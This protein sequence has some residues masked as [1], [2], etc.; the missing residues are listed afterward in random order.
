[1]LKKDV[2]VLLINSGFNRRVQYGFLN[3]VVTPGLPLSL[4][5]LGGYLERKGVRVKIADEQVDDLSGNNLRDLIRDFKPHVVGLSC[6]TPTVYRG[7]ELAERIKSISNDT[8]VVMGNAHPSI[9]PEECLKEENIDLVIRGEGEVTFWECIEWLQGKREIDAILGLSFKKNGQIQHNTDRPFVQ[10]L[11]DFPNFAYHLLMTEPFRYNPGH[12]VTSRGCPYRCIFCSSRNLSGYSYRTFSPQRVAE[13]VELLIKEYRIKS[14]MF[15]DDNFVVNRNRTFEICE[16]FLRNGYAK[17]ITWRCQ[18]RG[19]LVDREI[20]KKM[21]EAGCVNISFGIETASQRLLDLI[22]KNEKVEDNIKAVQLASEVG[23]KTRGAF[24]LGLPTET[25]EESM[26]T[27]RLAKRLPL[28]EVKFSLATP[29]PGTELYNIAKQR[30]YSLEGKWDFLNTTVGLGGYEPVYCPAGRTPAELKALQRRAHLEFYLRPHI[31]VNLFD[32]HQPDNITSLPPIRNP[33]ILFNYLKIIF[34]FLFET[35]KLKYKRKSDKLSVDEL[36]PR[37]YFLSE[38]CDGYQ[39]FKRGKELSYVK[40]KEV[41]FLDPQ[42]G[43]FILD[44]GC[45]RGELLFYCANQGARVVGI[46][47]ASGAIELAKETLDK[48]GYILKARAAY[49]PFKDG[50]FDKVIL[51][52]VLEHLEPTEALACMREMSRVSRLGGTILIHTS[53]NLNFV[54]ISGLVR[55][56]LIL[57]GKTKLAKVLHDKLRQA[58]HRHINIQSPYSFRRLI[59][60]IEQRALVWI[61]KDFL[62][63]GQSPLTSELKKSKFL[64]LI[65]GF[66]I[67]DNFLGN[68][69]WALIKVEKK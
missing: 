37:D 50:V 27:I 18:A 10:N 30:G 54:R 20:L 69:L 36:Y 15:D 3:T 43:E 42:T 68:D 35:I 6:V 49:L 11:D 52:D 46:E 58:R 17:K 13:H 44:V 62:R 47:Y 2:N 9:C 66:K 48:K 8:V 5:S 31:I 59:N 41:G 61:D 56:G 19:D 34:L 33:K 1:M 63:Q 40:K 16:I 22:Q 55:F 67:F 64:D 53:P 32:P 23:I 12:I 4:G 29:Y 57:L 45:G 26:E 14:L 60:Q 7:F 24:I 21:K 25:R 39:E 65:K 38:K 28:D 51:A